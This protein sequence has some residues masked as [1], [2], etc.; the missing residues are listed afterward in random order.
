METATAANDVPADDAHYVSAIET[1]KADSE[2]LRALRVENKRLKQ[3]IDALVDA[4]VE[5]HRAALDI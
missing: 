3:Q 1:R 4:L 2:E 5:V